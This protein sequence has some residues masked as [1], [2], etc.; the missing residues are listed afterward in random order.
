MGES[1]V[2]ESKQ[3][4]EDESKEN[5]NSNQT[6]S[7]ELSASPSSPTTASNGICNVYDEDQSKGSRKKKEAKRTDIRYRNG[8][9]A[10]KRREVKK[11][12]QVQE[13]KRK[14]EKEEDMTK[15]KYYN[16][17]KIQW[18]PEKADLSD[19][20][21]DVNAKRCYFKG[22][23]KKV[24]LIKTQCR[25]CSRIFCMQ[26]GPPIFHSDQCAKEQK[27][28][29]EKK[30]KE[31]IKKIEKMQEHERNGTAPLSAHERKLLADKLRDK[32]K[33]AENKRN[34]K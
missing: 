5:P 11:Q 2:S 12:R 33:S 23:K 10:K 27:V 26:H 9:Q 1:T 32:L 21:V 24:H 18:E 31:E 34:P 4:I 17:G 28:K 22:C 20:I 14:K 13:K 15:V 30:K 7:E 3:N 6:I 16:D 29:I 19:L 25:F 8:P